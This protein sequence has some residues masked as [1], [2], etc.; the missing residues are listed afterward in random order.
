MSNPEAPIKLRGTDLPF[1]V[2]YRPAQASLLKAPFCSLV[3]QL[4]TGGN[5]LTPCPIRAGDS[6]F[7]PSHGLINLS[8]SPRSPDAPKRRPNKK[9]W[10]WVQPPRFLRVGAF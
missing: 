10:T 4:D 8:T 2:S 5:A 6:C 3:L 7:P 1:G 9:G